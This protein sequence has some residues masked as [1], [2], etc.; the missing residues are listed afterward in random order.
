MKKFTKLLG[1]VLI[2]ALVMSMGISSAFAAVNLTVT[3]DSS[4]AGE[5]AEAGRNYNWYKV[6]SAVPADDFTQDFEGGHDGATPVTETG[7]GKVSYVATATVAGKL[8]SWVA[9]TG[10]PGETGYVAAHWQKA[11][12]NLWF[13]LTPIAGSDPATFNVT[14]D[15]T[16]DATAANVQAAAQWLFNNEVYEDSGELSFASGKWT[17]TVEEGYYLVVSVNEDGDAQG[18][19]ANLVAATTDID[20]KEK[21]SYPPQDKTQKDEDTDDY[22]DDAVDVAV[23]DVID[24][25]VEVTIPDTAKV[26]DQ[27][28]VWDKAT[29]GLEMVANSLKVTNSNPEATVADPAAGDVD[30]SWTWSKLITVT[31]GS[32][33]KKVV[34]TFQMTVTDEALVDTG[35]ENESG[36]KYGRDG[37]WTY[38]SKP[39][40]VEYK[41]YYAGIHK[42]DGDTNYD[43][44]GVKF[45]LFEDGVAFNVTKVDGEDY[46]IPGGSSNEVVTDANGLIHIRGLD[47]DKTYTL[48]E[49]ETLPGYNMLTEDITL[50]LHEDTATS[51]TTTADGTSTTTVTEAYDGATDKAWEV[52]VENNTGTVLP[53]TGGIGTTIFYVVGS[54]LVVAAGVL[55]ITKK[56]MSREG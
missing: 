10:T 38:E 18:T 35:K 52:E 30:A 24:Y 49:T 9:A 29:G 53:S 28:L 33:G 32:Q 6:F 43:L 2:M 44:E 34:F 45:D 12:G 37:D 3:R 23:G 13:D 51:T 19:G 27:I 8:G 47:E 31:A 26:G 11:T 15:E 46:Y 48:T 56:R 5:A 7:D 16:V 25:Q 40:H 55:L 54:I 50:A 17:A 20:I 42:I 39:D 14:W 1:I 22:G 21:N 41:T 36:I 4:Y